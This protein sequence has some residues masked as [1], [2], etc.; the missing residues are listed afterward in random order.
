M[1]AGHET[2]ANVLHFSFIYLAMNFIAQQHLQSDI[3]E[4]VGSRPSSSWTYQI[5]MRKLFN[6]MVGA[7]LHETLRMI[8]PIMHVPKVNRGE[9]KQVTIDG[10]TI[11]VPGNG[12]YLH[13]ETITMNRSP[14]YFPH[15]PSKV[16]SCE[17][18]LEDYVPERWLRDSADISQ[19]DR[20][21]KQIDGLE[22]ASF[23]VNGSLFRPVKGA[24]M[25]FSEGPR[26][27]PGRRFAEVEVIAVLSLVFKQ[28][29]VELD[30]RR[31]ATDE[32]VEKMSPKEKR[33]V[34]AKAQRRAKDLIRGSIST[35]TLKMEGDP[36]PV[37]F[38]RRGTESFS[39]L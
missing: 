26:A 27:C 4:V 23:E 2:T 21:E 33:D 5:D 37:R 14:R 16:T 3:D 12:T 7:V 29:S 15:S 13:M 17:H 28:Y 19:D 1:F 34:Y 35:F 36:V 8:P 39:R 9:P 30:V 11:S 22:V 31:W 6:S 38:V 10:K 32:E 18:D 25:P 20:S 24:W